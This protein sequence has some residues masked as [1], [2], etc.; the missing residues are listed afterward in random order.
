MT[1]TVC[2]GSRVREGGEERVVKSVAL[3]G[4]PRSPSTMKAAHSGG[5]DEDVGVE[6]AVADVD[7]VDGVEVDDMSTP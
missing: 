5:L 1:L 3:K 7:D 4:R 6:V 2:A